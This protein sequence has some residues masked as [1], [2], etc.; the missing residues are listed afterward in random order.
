MHIAVAGLLLAVAVPIG[1]L[2]LLVRFDPRVRSP[3]LVESKSRYPLLATIPA[4]P[5]PRE[6]RKQYFDIGI[7]SVLVAAV[8]L[9]YLL[10]YVQKLR[11]EEH[12]SELQS[13]I[14][15]SYA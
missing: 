14:R 1:L 12:T 11:S 2:W 5:S 4:Y 15:I 6:R 8:V 13:L 3:Q 7:G 10:T 9:L